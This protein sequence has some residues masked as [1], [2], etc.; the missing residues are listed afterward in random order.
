MDTVSFSAMA[1]GTEA[2]YRLLEELERN[3]VSDLPDRVIKALQQLASGLGGYQIDRLQH[4]LQA[5]TRA[6][7]D[8]A[9]IEWIVAALVHDIGDDLAPLNHSQFAAAMIRPYVRAEVTWTIEMHGLFQMIY[10]AHHVGMDP[11][12]RDQHRDHPFYD[13]CVRFCERWDQ[14]SFDPE[15]PTR[16]LDHFAPMVT[17]IFS[18]PA[19]DPEIVSNGQ[20]LL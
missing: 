1:D 11:N 18:R 19:F 10:Y 20:E 7:D 4:S 15:Y 2:D 13:S 6:E 5:A 17:E 9:D 14:S 16:S 3:H 8:G 12:G